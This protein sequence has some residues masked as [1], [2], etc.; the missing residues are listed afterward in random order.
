MGLPKDEFPKLPTM[1]D[2]EALK[3]DQ[4]VLKNM[5]SMTAFAISHDE[6]RYILNGILF[7]IAGGKFKM[8]ATDGRRLALIEKELGIPKQFHKNVIVPAKAVQELIRILKDEGTLKMFFTPNQI[9]FE[10]DNIIIIAS[11]PEPR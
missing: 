11:S 4:P 8:V 2:K 7:D 3:L 5:L 10:I 1:K 9:S 6:T